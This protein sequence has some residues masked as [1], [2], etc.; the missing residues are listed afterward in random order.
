MR[1]PFYYSPIFILSLISLAAIRNN[2]ISKRTA[3]HLAGTKPF[4]VAPLTLTAI[5]SCTHKVIVYVQVFISLLFL[6]Q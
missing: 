1:S 2:Y 5:N 3:W 4:K 6:I